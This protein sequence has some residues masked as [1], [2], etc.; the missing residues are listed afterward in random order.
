MGWNGGLCIV[1]KGFSEKSWSKKVVF[2]LDLRHTIL[3][4][5]ILR[6]M[7]PIKM[8]VWAL[9]T[10]KKAKKMRFWDTFL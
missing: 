8:R 5:P 9:K 2:S 4:K 10:N 1:L 6:F 3:D 7:K